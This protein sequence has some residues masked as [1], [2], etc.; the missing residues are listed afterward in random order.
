MRIARLLALASLAV[1]CTTETATPTGPT[2][3]ADVKPLLD[4][5]CNSCHVAD[6]IAPFALDQY[7]SAK[8]FAPS[9]KS[10]T[11]ARTMPPWL[12]GPGCSEYAGDESLTDAE[13]AMLGKWA[14]NGAPEGTPGAVSQPLDPAAGLSRV[15]LTLPMAQPYAP[16]RD[17]SDD[18]RCFL[19]DWPYDG[20]RFVTGFRAKP[21]NARV[22]HHVI[23][24]LVT[25]EPERIQKYQDLDAAEPG[26]GWTCYGA[27]APG[28]RSIGWLGA[29]APGSL[30]NDTPAGTGIRVKKGSKIALQVHYNTAQ[31]TA[32]DT[33]LTAVELKIDEQVDREAFILPWT[34]PLWVTNAV[35]MKIPA[36]APDTMQQFSFDP[37]GRYVPTVTNG[38]IGAGEAFDI[39]SA[40]FHMHALGT[41]GLLEIERTKQ[42]STECM[43]RIDHWDFNWQNSYRFTTPKRVEPGDK[44]R[45]ECHWD[46]TT[47]NQKYRSEPQDVT[48]GEGTGDEMCL[49]IL[50]ISKI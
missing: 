7:A 48:W 24:F 36:G 26:E 27:P 28:E 31:A 12:A 39:H 50:Y 33:D 21:G 35:P 8:T 3:H 17:G 10:S 34:N 37:T 41:T 25:P 47:A 23:A 14:D 44:I 46:N 38:V 29:W 32:A 15:D 49:G 11:A 40:S 1:A 43:L 19:L 4:R 13:I 2:W 22:V 20:D 5:R 18:Y 16:R 9:I 6:G 42:Q 30:G 45:I